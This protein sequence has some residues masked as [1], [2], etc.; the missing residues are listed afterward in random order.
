M[1]PRCSRK[2]RMPVG[3]KCDER[4]VL[5]PSKQQGRTGIKGYHNA[6]R[7]TIQEAW[8]SIS[9]PELVKISDIDKNERDYF[10]INTKF[11][12]GAEFQ[13]SSRGYVRESH[14]R[15][16]VYHYFTPDIYSVLYNTVR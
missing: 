14:S 15:T 5:A 9:R 4:Q 11:K 6:P 12:Q 2:R 13:L 8:G 16:L 3:K 7:I 1:R 10:C